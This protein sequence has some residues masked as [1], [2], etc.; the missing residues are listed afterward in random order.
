M[1]QYYSASARLPWFKVELNSLLTVDGRTTTSMTQLKSGI[2]FYVSVFRH[3]L[4]D[5]QH[6]LMRP[7]HPIALVQCL[8]R[9]S[10]AL[11]SFAFRASL[12]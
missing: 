10:D 11:T 12:S 1:F 6:N 7:R 5:K 9:P 2:F 8:D 4:R 3:L